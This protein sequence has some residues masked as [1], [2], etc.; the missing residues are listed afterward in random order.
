MLCNCAWLKAR[1]AVFEKLSPISPLHPYFSPGY[2]PMSAVICS[3]PEK[4]KGG[5]KGGEEGFREE[6]R[7][8]SNG[9]LAAFFL[10][11]SALWTHLQ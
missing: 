4:G 2:S 6:I 10:E 11:L 5:R 9:E 1:K 8:E 3:S 7:E